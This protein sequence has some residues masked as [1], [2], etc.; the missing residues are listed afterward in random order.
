V[1]GGGKK[2]EGFF[3]ICF[4]IFFPEKEGGKDGFSGFFSYQISFQSEKGK[5]IFIF[6]SYRE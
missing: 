1:G 2:K 6:L 4:S 5:K 3:R